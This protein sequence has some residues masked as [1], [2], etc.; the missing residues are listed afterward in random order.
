ME[1]SCS[2]PS[3][4]QQL[5]NALPS[6]LGLGPVRT[7]SWTQHLVTGMLLMQGSACCAG[8]DL[9]RDTDLSLFAFGPSLSGVIS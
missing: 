3:S 8:L 7:L 5:P 9:W 6:H 4:L 2:V 1:D